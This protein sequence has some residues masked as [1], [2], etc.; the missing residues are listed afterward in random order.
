[1]EIWQYT[2]CREEEI[3]PFYRLLRIYER[4]NAYGG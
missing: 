2:C 4:V 3:L 1:M